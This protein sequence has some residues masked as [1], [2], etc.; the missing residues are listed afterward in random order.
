[1][2]N[3]I[4]QLE[5]NKC[6]GCRSCE[7]VCPKK[8][9][10]MKDDHEGF[11]M[12]TI[13]KE[14]CINCG[15]CVRSCPAL[16]QSEH[17]EISPKVY[18]A[19]NNDFEIV[20]E[21]TSGGVFRVLAEYFIE[22]G[23][24]V[25]GCSWNVNLEAEHICVSEKKYLYKLSGSKYVQSNTLHSFGK[26]K[27]LLLLG[28]KVLFSGTSCQIAGLKAYLQKEYSNLFTVDVIC[29]G[30]PSPLLF[31]R[32]LKWQEEL[33][34]SEILSIDFRNYDKSY[35]GQTYKSRIIT[36]KKVVYRNSNFDPYYNAFLNSSTSRECCY[37]CIYANKNK[38][39]DITL[40]DFWGVSNFHS[41]IFNKHGVSCVIVN[42]ENG[43]DLMDNIKNH[44][45]FIESD[46]DNVSLKNYNLVKASN[47]PND[48]NYIYTNINKISNSELFK[49]RLFV[50]VSIK[51]HI[52]SLIPSK[53]KLYLRQKG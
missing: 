31:K 51:K 1:M 35:W 12:P 47:R 43:H 17:V 22:Q 34:G 16:I 26:V 13:N 53:V 6:F 45:D 2:D 50:K 10:I 18:A 19:V 8:C 4:N 29:H 23:G 37:S 33:I 25:F 11:L 27:D 41:N 40:G 48:R 7:Q 9:I 28:K 44:I 24:Y 15:L 21:S 49:E 3:T 36:N 30:V 14:H 42:T 5:K 20:R 32:Y 39:S 52:I 46:Y 38:S